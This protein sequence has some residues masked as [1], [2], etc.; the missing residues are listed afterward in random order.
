MAIQITVKDG[1]QETIYLNARKSLD[2]NIMVFDHPDIDI[3][4][5]P[6]QKKVVAFAKDEFGDHVYA[7]QS[8]L[9]D[10]LAKRGVIL[11]ESINGGSIYSSLEAKLPDAAD[12]NVDSVEVALYVVSKFIN[13]E[14]PF[15]DRVD[16]YEKE[17]EKQLLEPDDE[18]STELGEIPH[19]P[20]KG[21]HSKNPGSDAAYTFYGVMR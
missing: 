5:S 17:L 11:M 20:R 1:I 15:Y 3:I 10:Y 8:R 9:F 6:S 7:S 18:N 4:I 14:K 12:E 13:E 21:S 2:G 16:H 19:E